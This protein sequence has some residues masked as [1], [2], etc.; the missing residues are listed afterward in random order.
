MRAQLAGILA[1]LIAAAPFGAIGQ[2]PRWPRDTSPKRPRGNDAVASRAGASGLYLAASPGSADDPVPDPPEPPVRLKKKKPR[3]PE[4]PNAKP[5]PAPEDKPAKSPEAKEPQPREPREPAED[6]EKEAAEILARVGKNMRA[7]EERL[8]QKDAGEGTRQIQRDILKDLDSLIEQTKRQQ[9]QQQQQNAS[10]SRER[11]NRQT[12][13]R[14]QPQ[15]QPTPADKPAQGQQP[16]EQ[17]AQNQPGKGGKGQR[18][19]MN[20]IADLYKE[21]WGHLPET[22]RQEM[23]QYAR[24]QFMPRYSE[25][26]KQYYATIAEKGHRKGE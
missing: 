19:E 26:L 12:A 3:E 25:L 22:M 13:Q 24:E 9:Q 17:R 1:A 23:D 6:P 4:P 18:G 21:V 20:R 5:A 10:R 2:N 8:A 11:G 15:R 16:R 14:P 7:T